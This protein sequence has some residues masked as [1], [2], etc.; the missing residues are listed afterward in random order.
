MIQHYG[1]VNHLVRYSELLRRMVQLMYVTDPPGG[2]AADD[3]N[4]DRFVRPRWVDVTYASLCILMHTP[5]CTS[6]CILMHPHASSCTVS[7]CR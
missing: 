6:S 5:L 1:L 4:K 3:P 7:L 2:L